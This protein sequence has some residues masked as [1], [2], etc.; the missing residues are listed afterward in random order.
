MKRGMKGTN[1]SRTHMKDIHPER[2]V[3]DITHTKRRGIGDTN[4]WRRE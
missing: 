3:M 4:N 1:T 2:K